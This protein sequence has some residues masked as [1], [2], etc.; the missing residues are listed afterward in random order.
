MNVEGDVRKDERVKQKIRERDF[1]NKEEQKD[2]NV[3]QLF[4][5]YSGW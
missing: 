5:G 3:P 1:R 4:L 2:V